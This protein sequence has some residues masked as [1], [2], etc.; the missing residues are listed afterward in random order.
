M[1]SPANIN[2]R[3]PG[4]PMYPRAPII[5]GLLADETLKVISLNCGASH[6]YIARAARSLGFRRMFVT[7]A[8][9]KEVLAIRAWRISKG[10]V[11]A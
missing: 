3:G 11:A 4:R 7:D 8:E 5:A 2:R 1:K 9:R 10:K 6:S